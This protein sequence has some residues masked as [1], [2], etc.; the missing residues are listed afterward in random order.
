MKYIFAGDS[1]ALKE[2]TQENHNIGNYNPLPGDVRLADYWVWQYE[3]CVAPGQGNLSCMEK[4][5]NLNLPPHVPIIWVWTE[6]GRDYHLITGRPEFEWIESEKIF[7][8]RKTLEKEIY[9]RIRKD[10]PNPIGLIGGLCDIDVG[11]A[12]KHGFEILCTSWQ[13]WIADTLHSEWFVFGWGAG[14]IGWRADYNN[15]QPSKAALFAWDELIKEWCWWE[16]QGYFCHEHPSRQANKEFAA[17]MEP[18]VAAWLN[19]HG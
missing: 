13:K 17:Y 5:K 6:P 7:E 4:I 18:K 2:Y 12:E 11:L 15:V 16:D 19:L 1:W 14:D 10:I 3:L 8:I 9:S